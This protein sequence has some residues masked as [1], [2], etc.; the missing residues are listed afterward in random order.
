MDNIY[1]Y[2][3]KIH[4][5]MGHGNSNG[6]AEA[7]QVSQDELEALFN[8]A[9]NLAFGIDVEENLEKALEYANEAYKKGYET[10]GA[11]ARDISQALNNRTHKYFVYFS[12]GHV[13]RYVQE[14]KGFVVKRCFDSLDSKNLEEVK[15]GVE[16]DFDKDLILDPFQVGSGYAYINEELYNSFGTD[17]G[18]L[19]IDVIVVADDAAD[20]QFKE[21]GYSF[22]N[23]FY[24]VETKEQVASDL[25]SMQK[26]IDGVVGLIEGARRGL[27]DTESMETLAN[28]YENGGCGLKSAQEAPG[29]H[30][31]AIDVLLD[32]AK[33]DYDEGVRKLYNMGYFAERFVEKINN[34]EPIDNEKAVI[35]ATENMSGDDVFKLAMRYAAGNGVPFNYQFS[36]SLLE[37][38]VHKKCGEAQYVLTGMKGKGFQPD[39]KDLTVGDIIDGYQL[40]LDMGYAP[41]AKKIAYL[42]LNSTPDIA[43]TAKYYKISGEHGDVED[44]L[45]YAFLNYLNGK[46]KEYLEDDINKEALEIVRSL[47]QNNAKVIAMWGDIYSKGMFGIPVDYAR[48]WKCYERAAGKKDVSDET[49]VYTR[50]AFPFSSIGVGLDKDFPLPEKPYLGDGHSMCAMAE[51]ILLGQYGGPRYDHDKAMQL[52]QDANDRM[53]VEAFVLINAINENDEEAINRILNGDFDGNDAAQFI[54]YSNAIGDFTASGLYRIG[55]AMN[56][57]AKGE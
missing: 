20:K 23:G 32:V 52:L 8:K 46:L 53:D 34:A 55:L 6:E 13:A 41:A 18:A 2:A 56:E 57:A 37:I 35:A 21:L 27:L 17:W 30:K 47:P 16:T 14:K 11:L 10:A 12:A 22:N 51:M 7:K 48:A 3:T 49:D 9:Y 26:P 24:R 45:T 39:G 5:I 54:Q 40:A 29:N 4:E 38:A 43:E 42:Y 1:I 19:P 25:Q 50:L 36:A 28:G 33:T 44:M 31:L 15:A